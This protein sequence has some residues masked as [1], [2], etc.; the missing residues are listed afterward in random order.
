[1]VVDRAEFWRQVIREPREL[2]DKEMLAETELIL[3]RTMEQAAAEV[4]AT[5][6]VTAQALNLVTAGMALQTV[7]KQDR[8]KITLAA[9]VEEVGKILLVLVVLV[10]VVLVVLP[11]LEMMMVRLEPQ[12]LAAVVV[13]AET[14][15]E[16]E[17][18][19]TA[20]PV[21]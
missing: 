17:K 12:I 20:V 3:H 14:A 9:V 10:V 7:I 18:V 16:P 21:S 11:F 4:Q 1:M 5:S 8:L 6:E 2:A 13:E 15:L 19:E